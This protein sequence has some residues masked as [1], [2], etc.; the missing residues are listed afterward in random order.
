MSKTT[1]MALLGMAML[2]SLEARGETVIPVVRADESRQNLLQEDG[3]G[4]YQAAFPFQREGEAFVCDNK[5]SAQAQGGLVQA[6]ELNQKAPQ[7]ILASLWS[8]AQGVGGNRDLDYSLYLDLVY[9]DGESLWGQT[10]SFE[11]GSHDW[12]RVNVTVFP[13]KPVKRV[14]FHMLFRSHT[15]KA[16]FKSPWLNELTQ[17]EGAVMLDGLAVKRS[18]EGTEGFWVRDAAADSDFHSLAGGEALGLKL[19]LEKTRRGEAEFFTGRLSDTTGKDRAVTLVYTTPVSGKDWRW[20]SNARHDVAAEPPQEY[21]TT[22]RFEGLGTERLSLYPFAAV[23]RGEEGQA[24]AMDMGRPAFFRVGFSAGSGELYVAYDVGLAPE[25][26]E[27]EFGFCRYGFKGTEGFRGAVARLYELFPE[28]FR[29][30]TPEQGNWMPFYR[31]SRLTGWEDF[32]FK[33]KE[34]NDETAWDDAHGILTFRY[35][36]PMTWW[37]RMPAEMPRT[38]EA[39]LAEARRLAGTGDPKAQAWLTSGFV[40]RSGQFRALM[41]N[42]PWCNGAV[43]SMNS[44]PGIPGEVTDFK[45]KWNSQLRDKLYGEGRQGDLDGEYIDSSEGYV[46]A[47]LDFR[48]EHLAAARA[49]LTF[50]TG[51]C[52]PAVFRGLIVYEYARALAEQVHPMGKLMM[53]NGT[54]GQLCWLAPWLD[55]MGT[56]WDWNR[57]G[58]WGPPSDEQL[59]YRRVMCG[60]KPYCFLMNTDF[61]VFSHELV[62]RYMKRCL[63]YGM[64]PGFFS[65]NAAEKPYFSQPELYN[66]DRDLFRKY[67]PLCKQVAEAG[68]Q[69]VSRALSNDQAVYV[70][71]FGERYLTVFNDSGA[72]KDVVVTLTGKAPRQV[73]ELVSGVALPLTDGK[74]GMTLAAED[75]AVMA[76]DY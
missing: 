14:V 29:C 7:P 2:L 36:E 3:W 42:D 60:P 75:V 40:D 59:L 48:R 52:R 15:G 5:T 19:K 50:S 51:D 10:A 72:K 4:T 61:T 26:P 18:G 73:R 57:R 34:G 33:F 38:Q 39:A 1:G 67:L 24:V 54:P 35:T 32:G 46:T 22:T 30:R 17:P 74:I 62:E 13:T 25:K 8:K 68:W 69:P 56:E 71:R 45:N 28:Y 47:A 76:L 63:A 21:V 27:A 6:V 41:R 43:W 31:I 65:H 12:Q 44:S 55:V 23:G 70:E 66:R 49:A 20:L 16:L 9:M 53:A 58:K 11:V 64:F 37:M